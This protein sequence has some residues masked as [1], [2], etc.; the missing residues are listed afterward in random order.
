M[1]KFISRLIEVTDKNIG[2]ILIINNLRERGSYG[3]EYRDVFN[4]AICYGKLKIEKIKKSIDGEDVEIIVYKRVENGYCRYLDVK[5]LI[6]KYCPLCKT[7][8]DLDKEYCNKEE[9][10]MKTGKNKGQQRKLKLKI[11][12][13]DIC[14]LNRGDF[15]KDGEMG[16]SC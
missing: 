9:C 14:Q 6:I 1:N 3:Q 16:C 15:I 2:E 11:S 8:Y 10:L 5:N 4:M 12:N 7:S 13:K